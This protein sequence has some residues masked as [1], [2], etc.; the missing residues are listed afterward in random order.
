MGHKTTWKNIKKI[1]REVVKKVKNAKRKM[2]REIAN[3]KDKNNRKFTTYLK[4]KTKSKESVGPLKDKEGKILTE[5]KDIAEELNRFFT[6]VFTDEDIHT[7]PR[8]ERETEVGLDMVGVTESRVQKQ[9]KN[10]RGG[11]A[12]GPDGISP[13][14]LKELSNVLIEPMTIIFNRSLNEQKVPA[15]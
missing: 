14:L 7:V 8:K 4:S 6:G 5:E 3:A 2:E 11:A 15:A 12:P 9:I 10:L 1:E 13:Q